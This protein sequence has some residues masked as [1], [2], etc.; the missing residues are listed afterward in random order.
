MKQL[1]LAVASAALLAGAPAFAANP[2]P[3]K[4]D[5]DKAQAAAEKPGGIFQPESASS[6]GQVAVEG[7]SISYHAVAGTIVVHPKGWDDSIAKAVAA[8][9]SDKGKEAAA[10]GNPTAEASMFYVAYFKNGAP[11]ANRP[12]TFF[13]NGGPG[14]ST[15]WLHMG[16]FGPR[17]VVTA[18]DSHTPAAPYSLVD[19]AYSLLDA[20]DLVF[21][22]APG[23]GFSRIAG[24]DKEKSFWGVDADAHAFSEFILQFLSKYGRWNSPKYLFGESYGTP[25]SA[26][27]INELE[28]ADSVDFNGVILLSQILNFDMSADG[29]QFNPGT[30]EAYVAALPTYAAT[31]WYHNLLPGGRPADLE[32]YLKRVE[33]FASGDYAQALQAGSELDPARKQAIADQMAKY[34][35]LPA[36]YI[37]KADLRVDGGMFEKMLQDQDGITTGRLD[38]RFSGPDMDPLSKEADYDPQSAS[39]SSAYVSAFNDYVR[40]QLGFGEG[41]TYKPETDVGRW[42]ANHQPPGVPVP[43]PGI[44]NV[45]P[46]LATAMKYDPQLKIMVN[47][48]YFD[49]ATP[50]YEG[51][52][53][54]HHLQIP[55]T[56][57]NN[58][59][60]HYYQS[61][62]M[63]YAHEASLK[64]IHDN[65]ASFIGR[66]DN[67]GR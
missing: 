24:K 29:P 67:Q 4:T 22:D 51:W 13:Y 31:A 61:G 52:Y 26:V 10:D 45:M 50:F 27:V 9:S 20:T 3:A 63:V 48:G 15:V 23:T 59:E 25:R 2:P 41:K 38:T 58:I 12:I 21:I 30:D 19:N 47:G 36:A 49:L 37:L 32:P 8:E 66:T 42:D 64:E 18:D 43:L 56:L 34:I 53:E 11:S 17:R 46:D 6:E 39:I 28:T 54:D 65:V 14:S 16:A 57:Q 60:Y 40:K 7:Q 44:L 35:G 5:S 1:L 33:A 55:V 62:H